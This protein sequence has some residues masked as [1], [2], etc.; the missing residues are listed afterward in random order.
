MEINLALEGA[1]LRETHRTCQWGAK[2]LV[3]A[4]DGE[5]RTDFGKTS[6]QSL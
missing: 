4:F 6:T 1:F 3:P 5:N 2:E